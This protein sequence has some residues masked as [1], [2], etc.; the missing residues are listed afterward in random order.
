MEQNTEM[1]K[2]NLGAFCL[3]AIT[4][5]PNDSCFWTLLKEFRRSGDSYT[6]DRHK[7]DAPVSARYFRFNPTQR[8]SWNCLRVEIYETSGELTQVNVWNIFTISELSLTVFTFCLLFFFS[9]LG[10]YN[11][12]STKAKRTLVEYS[13]RQGRGEYSPVLTLPKT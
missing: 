10:L 8:H 3:I 11:N 5:S 6:I 12:Y 2:R 4:K 9:N 1:H 13:P 7:L